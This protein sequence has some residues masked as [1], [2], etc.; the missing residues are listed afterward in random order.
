M[1]IN[2]IKAGA[3]LNYVI[4]FLNAVVGLL[5]TPYLLRCLGQSEYGLYSLVVP[6]VGYLTILDFGFG[7]AVIRYTAKF[8]AEGKQ[9]EQYEMFGMFVILYSVIALVAFIVG[10]IL[11]FNVDTLFGDTLTTYELSRTKILMLILVFNLAITFPF[12]I[13]GSIIT[14]YE[15]FVFQK[16]INIA[17]II[18]NTVV[19]IVLL[20]QG[21]KAV[22]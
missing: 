19:M 12:S 15:D 11:Y 5:Y 6:I 10:L 18:L 21:Y 1:R 14:A 9:K 22:A 17:R 3:V 2:Q 7:N 4:I 8:R 20:H 16:T 13:F